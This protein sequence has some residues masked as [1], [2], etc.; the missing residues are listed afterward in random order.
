MLNIGRFDIQSMFYAKLELWRSKSNDSSGIKNITS[1]PLYPYMEK[2][3]KSMEVIAFKDKSSILQV[4][5]F[6]H[7]NL[8]ILS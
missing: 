4:L 8:N 3:K 5:T 6:D 7:S 1:I 2:E